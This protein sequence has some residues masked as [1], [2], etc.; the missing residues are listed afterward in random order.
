VPQRPRPG[1]LHQQREWCVVVGVESGTYGWQEATEQSHPKDCTNCS[2]KP[3]EHH[4]CRKPEIYAEENEGDREHACQASNAR[5]LQCTIHSIGGG[6]PVE[7]SQVSL[8]VCV[9][10]YFL[11]SVRCVLVNCVRYPGKWIPNAWDTTTGTSHGQVSCWRVWKSA[12][13]SWSV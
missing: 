11:P 9:H 7:A 2:G 8:E 1:T 10:E 3:G 6:Q 12:G 13:Q 4:E 5:A